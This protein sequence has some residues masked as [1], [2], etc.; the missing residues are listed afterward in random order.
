MGSPL[1]DAQ[2]K[3]VERAI[4]DAASQ[5]VDRLSGGTPEAP[6]T[7]RGRQS[8]TIK[9]I[10]LITAAVVVGVAVLSLLAK[11]WFLLMGLAV[12]AGL[13]GVTYVLAR[14]RLNALT[15]ARRERQREQDARRL[16][17]QAEQAKLAEARK[18]EEQL[19]ALKKRRDG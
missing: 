4:K 8:G 3:V 19:A 14:P 15:E 1:E 11:L 6:A 12:L 16:A 13:G 9:L 5:A 17:E 7:E 2:R 10:L 18:L